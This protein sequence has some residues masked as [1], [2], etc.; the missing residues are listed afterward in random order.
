MYLHEIQNNESDIVDNYRQYQVYILVNL[1]NQY[2]V[3][4]TS[5]TNLQAKLHNY[6][7]SEHQHYIMLIMQL[8]LW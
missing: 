5:A 6:Q 4:I 7:V 2:P 1:P 8:I 3:M